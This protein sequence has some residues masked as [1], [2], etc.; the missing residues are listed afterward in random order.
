MQ[1]D[2][3]PNNEI[4][5][6]DEEAMLDEAMDE[7]EDSMLTASEGE[8]DEEFDEDD[9]EEDTDDEADRLCPNVEGGE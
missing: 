6:I 3:P 7:I 5:D 4:D 8:G 2:E 1:E 9:E